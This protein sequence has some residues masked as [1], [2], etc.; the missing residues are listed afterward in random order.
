MGR[1]V[2]IIILIAVLL[3]LIGCSNSDTRLRP[4]IEVSSITSSIGAV[5]ENTK[6]FDIQSFKYTIALINNDVVDIKIIS[7]E[8]ELSE[9]FA[10]RAEDRSTA[11]QVDKVISSGSSID[12]SGEIIFDAKGMSKEQIIDMEP[13]VIDIKIVE[14]RIINKSF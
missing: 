13:F 14:E 5:G 2:S 12:V 4:G 8:P 11:I 10:K 6:N 1:R 3:L 9:E 7:V